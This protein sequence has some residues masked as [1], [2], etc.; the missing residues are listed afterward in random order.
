MISQ[1]R[2][3]DK[4]R[5]SVVMA[6]CNGERYLS[7]QLESISRQSLRPY[8]LVVS[9][10]ASTD[11]TVDLL[12]KF[13]ETAS[14]PVRIFCNQKRVGYRENFLQC[15]RNA[16]CELIAYSDQD[17][18]WLPEKL[19]LCAREFIDP[20][21]MLVAHEVNIADE[22]LKPSGKKYYDWK[23]SQKVQRLEGDI[24]FNS[25]G[26]TQTF[27]RSLVSL[28]AG[29]ALPYD[30]TCPNE[31]L[32]HD[33][34]TSFMA[35]LCGDTVYLARPLALYRRHP[36]TETQSG[37]VAKPTFREK[38]RVALATG[39]A[40]YVRRAEYCAQRAAFVDS[41]LGRHESVDLRD[42][43][44]LLRRMEDRFRV[45]ASMYAEAH[46]REKIAIFAKLW[47]DRSYSGQGGF[48]S[49]ALLKDL[50]LLGM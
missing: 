26:F 43:V 29:I 37:K 15:A 11:R 47:R 7:E 22:T 46:M 2:Q 13:S 18:R 28:A 4:P 10:D 3:N 27:R 8:E 33:Q 41:M 5:V 49:K 48:G 19:E 21:V 44:A 1:V 16:H 25:L 50:V 36:K 38:I 24:W 17:D 40:D 30:H 42:A 12:R 39:Q 34:L 45:R 23:K 14:F 32:A 35:F 31:R 20:S 9:D 6:T